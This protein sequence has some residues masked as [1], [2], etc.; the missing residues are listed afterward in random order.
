VGAVAKE[1]P[2]PFTSSFWS[3]NTILLFERA[4]YYAMASLVVIYLAQLGFGNYWPSLI[5]SIIW[6]LVYYLPLFSGAVADQAGFKRALLLAFL[7]LSLGY[8]AMGCPVWLGAEKL[9]DT[10]SNEYSASPA[11]LA[12]V[13]IGVLFI[14]VGSSFV[15]PCIAGTVQ[16]LNGARLAIG[17]AILFMLIHAGNLMGRIASFC[18]RRTQNFDLSS[19][20]IVSSAAAAIALL[21]TATLFKEPCIEKSRSEKK[22]KISLGN[23]FIQIAIVL[24]KMHL[25][26]I[27]LITSGFYLVYSQI[28]NLLPLYT[29]K[30]VELSPAMEIYTAANPFVIVTCQVAIIKICRKLPPIKSIPIGSIFVGISMLVNILP[31]YMAGGVSQ[32]VANAIPL[33]SLFVV[34]A[35]AM[36]AFGEIFT[37][38][39]LYEY[40]A[41]HSPKGQEGLYQGFA[42]LPMALGSIAGGFLGAWVFNEVMC[43]NAIEL[44]NKLLKLDTKQAALG[45][46]IMA[47]CGFASALS[48]LVYNHWVANR[49]GKGAGE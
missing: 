37:T 29:K 9:A 6:C 10:P 21:L 16:K 20:F 44:P 28:Y 17:F 7:L 13:S 1:K 27:L 4:A 32:L 36:V 46:I 18:L 43:K 31:I 30:T 19:I 14:G 24:K 33:G 12:F 15:R 41:A 42:N 26:I 2:E 40:F 39:R 35:V 47:A 22:P 34:I 23:T 25:A 38:S 49:A 11:T 48:M 3:A 8:F 5:N 45:W